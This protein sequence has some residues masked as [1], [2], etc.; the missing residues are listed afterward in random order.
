MIR[1]PNVEYDDAKHVYTLN[2]EKLFGVSSVAKIGE[3]AWG[4]A[5]WWGWKVGYEGAIEVFYSDYK[6]ETEDLKP[7]TMREELKARKL[8]P[9]HKRDKAAKRGT[10]IHDAL[11]VLA[12]K[13]EVPILE[14]FPE[15]EQG[16]VK[17]LCS[18]YLDYKPEFVATEVQVVSEEY[19]F[20]GR[21]DVRCKIGDELALVDLKTSKRVYPLSHFVQLAGYE[22][23]SV[24]MGYPPTDAQYVLR[25]DKDG[26]Y[27]FVRSVCYGQD[28]L[29]YLAASKAIKR[30]KGKL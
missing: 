15:E 26:S 9:N 17:G 2:G 3:D 8:T 23:A 18:W 16:Y 24:E 28:F 13:G 1:R 10:A 27:E 5:S 21:Y 6:W 30:I 29:D 12:Q 4:P 14:Q 7:E 22:L 20:A 19:G 25:V 11:E